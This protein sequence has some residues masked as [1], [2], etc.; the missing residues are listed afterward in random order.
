MAAVLVHY[1]YGHSPLRGHIILKCASVN[2]LY[3]AAKLWVKTKGMLSRTQ[4]KFRVN[5]KRLGSELKNV[6]SCGA[7]LR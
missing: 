2:T 4:K 5:T 1:N 6:V 3:N 7:D